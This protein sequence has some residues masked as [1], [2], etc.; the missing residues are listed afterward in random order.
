MLREAFFHK[1][2]S[3]YAYS[4]T[5]NKLLIKIRVKK[6]DIQTINVIYTDIFRQRHNKNELRKVQMK[7]IATDSLFDFFEAL[8]F[9]E[10]M[11]SVF[12]FFELSDGKQTLLYGDNHFFKEIEG[13][14]KTLPEPREMFSM[15]YISEKDIY[16]PPFWAEDAIV[17]QV[18]PDRFKNGNS[19]INPEN[20]K[21]WNTKVDNSAFLGGDLYG[22]IDTLE[23]LSELG[24]NTLYL[25]PIF[26]STSS[27]KY[28]TSDYY[29][30]DPHFGNSET[31]KELVKKAH[32][33][34]IRIIL[35]AVFNHCGID[36]FAF[37]DLVEKGDSSHYKTWFDVN[38]MPVK[39]KKTFPEYT[40][41]AYYGTM[42]KLMTK[43]DK[44]A[45]YLIDVGNYWIKEAD[46][47]GWRLDVADQ[48]DHHFWRKFRNAVKTIKPDVLLIGEVWK[49]ASSYLMGDQFDSV[50][51]YL[52]KFAIDEFIAKKSI[53]PE[54]F[55]NQLSIIRSAYKLPILNILWNLISS[56]DTD[57][58]LYTASGDK[59]K[60]KLAVLIQMT[61]AGCPVI[62]YGDELGMSGQ[63]IYN[64]MG[65]IWNK[66][67]RD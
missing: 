4:I 1:M 64:R 3:V 28:D 31:L 63:K 59:R 52:F 38:K 49:A 34:G 14:V 24:I 55:N 12:Y 23:Y 50:M 10:G 62:Y 8:L 46:I 51:N 66:E 33:R 5:K 60:L 35:D 15:P 25:T 22:I 29:S 37:K 21:P 36:F 42:P 32:Q 67:K 45:Q 2:D 61:Y 13:T 57:R 39:I 30:I 53:T 47:D 26:K 17:Y 7:K 9:T 40:C 43:D 18:V 16:T 44:V 56:H 6:N 19:S 20:T 48:V 58:F 65:M 54:Q 41:Y 27:H 11:V